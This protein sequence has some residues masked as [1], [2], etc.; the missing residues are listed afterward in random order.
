MEK[1]NNQPSVANE[2][3]TQKPIVEKKKN[4]IAK[5]IGIVIGSFIALIAIIVITVMTATNAPV[6]ISDEF[7]ANVQANNSVAA[8]DLMT[9]EAKETVTQDNFSAD[10]ARVA[11]ILTGEPTIISRE[12][13]AET[14]KASTATIVYE[15]QGTDAKYEMTLNLQ[16]NDGKWQVLNFESE[17]K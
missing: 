5:I 17:A 12:I 10:I 6:K 1:E 3:T 2:P 13:S 9:A 4:N 11:P 16:E 15:I 8:Y 14:G 7:I